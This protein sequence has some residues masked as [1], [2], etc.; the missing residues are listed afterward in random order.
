MTFL[1]PLVLFGL[2]AAAIPVILHFLNLR[3]LRKIEF[4]TLSFLKELKQTKIR[5]LKL[6]QILLLILRTLIIL[7]IVLAFAR[8]AFKNSFLGKIGSNAHSTIIIILDDSFSMA[9]RDAD[10]E[11]LTR[12]KRTALNIT[13]LIKE[14]DEALLIRLSDLPDATI[15]TPTH[16]VNLIRTYINDTKISDV[17]RKLDDAVRLSIK[18]LTRSIN[19]NKEIYIVTDNQQILY[20][21]AKNDDGFPNLDNNCKIILIPVGADKI[22][23]IAIDSVEVSSTILE[24]DKPVS[25]QSSVI[26]FSDHPVPNL[27]LSVY[28]N[29]NRVGQKNLSLE[30]YGKAK[31]DFLIIPKKN[32]FNSGYFQIEEDA[33]SQD[34]IRYFSFFIPE[35]INVLFISN[36]EKDIQLPRLSLSSTNSTAGNQSF[37]I[38]SIN[39][40]QISTADL[41]H[42]EVI[43]ISNI[44]SI[45][46]AQVNRIKEF[47]AAGGGLIIFPDNTLDIAE[48]NKTISKLL[49]ISTIQKIIGSADS[50]LNLTFNKIDF[51]HPVFNGMFERTE[52]RTDENKIESPLIFKMASLVSNNNAWNIILLSNNLPFLSE[53]SHG[54]GKIFLFSVAPTLDWSDFPLK[55][56]F[57]PLIHRVTQYA[58]SNQQLVS[59]FITGVQ[60][61]IFARTLQRDSISITSQTNFMLI[62]PD[63]MQESIQPLRS[64]VSLQN[65]NL[66]T[67]FIIRR[68]DD[69]GIYK[70]KAG[71]SQLSQFTLNIN[72]EESDTRIIKPGELKNFFLKYNTEPLVITDEEPSEVSN[73]ILQSRLGIELWKHLILLALILALV[74]MIV[75]RDSKKSISQ[76]KI[77]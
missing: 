17:T 31:N 45:N 24:K 16:D 71:Q 51:D 74:E 73:R 8:P 43:V 34:N 27:L 52:K 9:V 62:L 49:N 42:T 3:K 77:D 19:A 60:P 57:A 46:N 1:N 37:S 40:N 4:S 23:N 70:V 41:S 14:G 55:G 35:V 39:Q 13:S 67:G 50:P 10:G 30:S 61:H 38:K 56:I 15:E 53:Y 6:R 25:I 66:Q 47:T 69:P 36:S 59:S 2:I 18:L 12:A 58:V 11:R 21:R 68:I 64:S 5:R 26:N 28:L 7:F 76:S 75:A 48:F 63:G 54:K 65:S 33:L 29:G 44:S 22:P 20:S 72:P 32:G